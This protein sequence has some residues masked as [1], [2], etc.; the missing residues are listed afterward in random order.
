MTRGAINLLRAVECS[1]GG[2]PGKIF[3][4]PGDRR[5]DGRRSG[6]GAINDLNV[7]LVLLVF[8]ERRLVVS[9]SL[10]RIPMSPWR[11]ISGRLAISRTQLNGAVRV[12]W[13]G[14]PV[15]GGV[16]VEAEG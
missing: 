5:P 6:S 11:S 13:T 9:G 2:V 7:R 3:A 16:T 8:G 4:D 12:P 15:S 1:V 10:H 14:P